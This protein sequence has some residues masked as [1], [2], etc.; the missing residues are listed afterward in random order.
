M[1]SG[2]VLR[3]GII[4]KKVLW[5]S[6]RI[7]QVN[8]AHIL[9]GREQSIETATD[10]KVISQLKRAIDPSLSTLASLSRVVCSRMNDDSFLE[11]TRTIVSVDCTQRQRA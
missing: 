1:M 9:F 7:L 6:I 8:E 3:D 10:I 2:Y 4:G 5:V 11:S